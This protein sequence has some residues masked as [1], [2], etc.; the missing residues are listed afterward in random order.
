MAQ[1]KGQLSQI[2]IDWETVFN[3]DPSAAAAINMPFNSCGVRAEQNMI[4][5]QTI[6][7]RRD[8]VEPAFG[9]RNVS[10]P[11]VVPVDAI[12]IG[13]WLKA[14]LGAPVTSQSAAPYVHTFTVGDTIPSFL[15]ELGFTDITQF[16]KFNGCKLNGMTLAVGGDG[17]LTASLDILGSKETVAG[18]SYDSSPT[19]ITFTRFNNFQATLEEGGSTISNVTLLNLSIKNG[20][21][22][23]SYPIGA[24]GY[25]TQLLEGQCTVDGSLRLFF[26][27]L[28]L[29]NKATGL[30]ESSL[31]LKFT[32]SSNI[33]T[34]T[35]PEVKYKQG[36]PTVETPG[37]VYLELPFTAFYQNSSENS[38][39]KAVLENSLASYA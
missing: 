6:T 20:L 29:Y 22:P 5:P 1:A 10:G 23:D 30:T 27:N 33:L 7:G 9:N 24:N 14:L 12:G 34:I 3:A 8:G 26:E 15:L 16:F 39:I 21:D 36:G 35:L 17:E 11:C 13:Y 19:A 2:L 4:T 37:G 25:R 38:V 28:T 32:N 31:E 18:S